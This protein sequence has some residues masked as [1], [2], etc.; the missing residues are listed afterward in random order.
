MKTG[1]TI[2]DV[3]AVVA[4]SLD[5]DASAVVVVAPGR[6]C[7]LATDAIVE[8]LEARGPTTSFVGRR[9]R[10]IEP[11][12]ATDPTH[13]LVIG[14]TQWIP[15]ETF[16]RVVSEHPEGRT[17]VVHRP[18]SV[19][20]ELA[21]IHARAYEDGARLELAPTPRAELVLDDSAPGDAD[22]AFA[23]SQGWP[24]LLGSWTTDGSLEP[25]IAV[26]L[27]LLDDRTRSAAELVAFGGR[28][29]DLTWLLDLSAAEVDE[30]VG[31]LATDGFIRH[32]V[33]P[34]GIS[35]AV[36]ALAPPGRREEA[37]ARL[38]ERN[39]PG[40][41]VALAESLGEIDERSAAAAAVHR[42]AAD[43][44]LDVDAGRA[45]R[46]LELSL[47]LDGPGTEVSA[48]AVRIGAELDVR[49]GRPDFALRR[50]ATAPASAADDPE[51][52]LVAAVSWYALGDLSA[53]IAPLRESSM[54]ALETWAAIG[55]G[56]DSTP[57]SDDEDDAAHAVAEAVAAWWAGS[58]ADVLESLSRALVRFP[59]SPERLWPV[60]PHEVAATLATRLG[61]VNRAADVINGAVT[62]RVG[63]RLRHRSIV[64]LAAWLAVRQG[65]LDDAAEALDEV[66][67][68]EMT[69]RERWLRAAVSCALAVRDPEPGEVATSA[70]D[71]HAAAADIAFDH[72]DLELYGEIAAASERAG[73][74][75]IDDVLRPFDDASER[76]DVP[77][78]VAF[79]L[80]RVR[81]AAA[82]STDD[83]EIASRAARAVS[84]RPTAADLDAITSRMAALIADFPDGD[85]DV[86]STLQMADELA[87]VH[88]LHEAARL[89]GLAAVHS[90]D[91]K[92]ARRLLKESR[93]LRLQRARVR[94][95]RGPDRTVIKLSPQEVK[96]AQFVND[97]LTYKAIAAELIISPKTVEHHVAHIRSKL[98][99]GSRA[100]LLAAIRAYFDDPASNDS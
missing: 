54:P 37:I 33:M 92:A 3:G 77:E 28:A 72:Y 42:R 65:R 5:R 87:A 100:E 68:G 59:A 48:D 51:L 12:S 22:D 2:A 64:L 61:D 8:E 66:G 44:L 73:I 78:H 79:D 11:G 43:E 91:P 82:M 24:D 23:A 41:M 27:G 39:S 20:G 83:I 49:S 35:R 88:R 80:E 84:S 15:S 89:C 40:S 47:D 32:G 26:D 57:A 96:V 46:H 25:L 6:C 19:A 21:A 38:V 70:A 1:P 13:T 69:P 67:I 52:R 58:P 62:G 74:G 10:V 17:V 90:A 76:G 53:A 18:C 81:L 71:A 75:A 85:V 29:G 97:G 50:I 99:A 30:I 36:L 16:A 34:E 7:A 4:A 98:A 56:A 93:S 14:E 9:G 63:G 60:T 45:R 86:Q 95:E 31:S 55:V 94:E